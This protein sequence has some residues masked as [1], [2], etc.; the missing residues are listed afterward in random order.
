MNE[1]T[2]MVNLV[3]R[4]APSNERRHLWSSQRFW[5]APLSTLPTLNAK[6]SYPGSLRLSLQK[7]SLFVMLSGQ[8]II[9][10]HASRQDHP[11]HLRQAGHFVCCAAV[12]TIQSKRNPRLCEG[13][14]AS[15]LKDFSISEFH[16]MHCLL[17]PRFQRCLWRGQVFRVRDN[18]RGQLAMSEIPEQCQTNQKATRHQGEH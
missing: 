14:R 9:G 1:P 7:L 5:Q 2:R 15:T 17:A 4:W 6:A 8:S 16:D 10:A 11:K 18:L 3:F 12:P 13:F